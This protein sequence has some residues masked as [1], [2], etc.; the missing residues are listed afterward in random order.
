MISFLRAQSHKQGAHGTASGEQSRDAPLPAFPHRAMLLYNTADT[1][2]VQYQP[3]NALI[4]SLIRWHS[5]CPRQLLKTDFGSVARSPFVNFTRVNAL[6]CKCFQ[7]NCLEPFSYHNCARS[8]FIRFVSPAREVRLIHSPLTKGSAPLTE[9][10]CK[11]WT[12]TRST[13]TTPMSEKLSS[14]V[15]LQKE[16]LVLEREAEKEEA[17][18]A[19]EGAKLSAL[20]SSGVR[21]FTLSCAHSFY[22]PS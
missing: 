3:G 21:S 11:L 17:S 2:P 4:R 1:V 6:H 19:T 8:H 22:A 18:L 15:G 12:F 14:Y 20:Q 7:R 10:S 5:N 9:A 16:L 13:S